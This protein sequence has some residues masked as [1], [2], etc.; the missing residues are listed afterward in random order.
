MKTRKFAG[1]FRRSPVSRLR[2]DLKPMS[3]VVAPTD[4]APPS[5]QLTRQGTICGSIET[6]AELRLQFQQQHYFRL[7]QLIEPALLDVIQE[8]IEQGEFYE[9]VH[10]RI[11]S[12]KELCL[13]ENAASTALL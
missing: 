11:D 5:V 4:S 9:R 6:L 12:N 8:Q 2:C 7:P 3:N 10:T 1:I 13:R